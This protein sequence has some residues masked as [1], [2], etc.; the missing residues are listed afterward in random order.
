MRVAPRTLDDFDIDVHLVKE[1][2]VLSPDSKSSEKFMVVASEH[3]RVLD[4]LRRDQ[5]DIRERM[6]QDYIDHID[7]K[8]DGDLFNRITEDFREDQRSLARE[9]D[10]LTVADDAT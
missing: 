2:V 1:G 3:A 8:I 5:D 7:G 6:K 4:R 10:R 9:L